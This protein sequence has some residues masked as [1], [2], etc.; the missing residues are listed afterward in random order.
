MNSVHVD[1]FF[2]FS[3]K[4]SLEKLIQYSLHS[5]SNLDAHFVRFDVQGSS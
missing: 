5:N 1:R 2:G 4:F 3:L